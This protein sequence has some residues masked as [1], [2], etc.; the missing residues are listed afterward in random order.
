MY[1]VFKT[2]SVL[3]FTCAKRLSRPASWH[4]VQKC[5]IPVVRFKSLHVVHTK[6]DL[7]THRSIG[8]EGRSTSWT[9]WSAW[10]NARRNMIRFYF[11]DSLVSLCLAVVALLA[12][13]YRA[14]FCCCHYFV[15]IL[16]HSLSRTTA[17][18]FPLSLWGTESYDV[19]GSLMPE[20]NDVPT[21]AIRKQTHVNTP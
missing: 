9:N 16:R 2:I 5:N 12:E 14:I 15:G 17:R 3:F 21:S 13:L 18:R 11:T 7:P 20:N 10:R 19:K 6:G 1:F 8:V 4:V